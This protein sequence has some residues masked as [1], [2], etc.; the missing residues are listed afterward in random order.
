M[1]KNHYRIF[2]SLL[3]RAHRWG[4]VLLLL[5]MFLG[6]AALPTVA[7]IAANPIVQGVS[8]AQGL[9]Q[10]GRTL[11]ET[12]RFSEA[13]II[14]QRA[15]TAFQS[16]GNKLWQAATLS[17][18]SLVYQQLGEWSEAE[19]A[20]ASSLSLLETKPDPTPGKERFSSGDAT[21]THILAQTLDVRGR[22]Q[23]ARGQADSALNSWKRAAEVYAH[24]GDTSAAIRSRINQATA[25]QALGLY[26]QAQ[27]TLAEANEILQ[28]Q[29]DSALKAA[30]MHKLGNVLRISGD[31]DRA[32]AVLQQSLAVA[33]N[34]RSPQSI[35]EAL[36]SLG[37][38]AQVRGDSQSALNY[39]QQAIASSPSPA[40]KIQI[41]LNQLGLLLEDK[42][43]NAA[44]VL[45]PSILSQIDSLPSS[46]TSVYAR[47]D[48]AR[49]LMKMSAGGTPTPQD[50]QAGETPTPQDSQAGG[51][52]TPQDSQAGETPTPQEFLGR[53]SRDGQLSSEIAQMLAQAVRDAQNLK[54]R[55]AE[56]YALGTLGELYEHTQQESDALNLT[57]QALLIAQTIDGGD[58][59]YQ[60]QW[61]MG[62]LHKTQG[63]MEKAI[64]FYEQAIATL[65]SLR[66][67]LVAIDSNVQ[68]S[69]RE[70]VEPVYRQFV[71]LLLGSPD[72][73]PTQ[74]NLLKARQ[75]I[76]SLQLAEL[77]NFFREACLVA[78]RPIDVVVDQ[79]QTAAFIYPVILPERIEVIF[80]LPQQPLRRYNTSIAQAEV[81]TILAQL[82]QKLTEPDTVKEAQSLSQK[83]YN[84][85]IQPAASDL[86][87][88]QIKT[89]V[90]VLDGALRNIPMAALYDG[91]KY[92]VE[93]YAFALTPGLQLVEPKP[94]EQIQLQ[95]LI[96]G[97]SESRQGFPRL[98]YVENE[99]HQIGTEIPGQT[100]LN[101]QFT[102]QVF[103]NQI[104]L[105]P[106]PVVHLATHGQ[107]SSNA[108]RTFILAWDK[109]IKVNEL[110]SLLRRRDRRQPAAI[111][112]LV[113]SA[114]ET[115][116]GDGR[117]ALGLAGVAIRAG[118]RSTI[119]SLW[120]VEDES[121][122]LLMSQFYQGI[123]NNQLTKAESLRQAQL[124]L[125]QNPQ[126]KRPMSWA[127]YVLVGNWL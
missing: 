106:F 9:M 40:L 127:P 112:L 11:Y 107:F 85:L 87:Q 70:S 65:Q 1:Y 24:M 31:L 101:Q 22:L 63:E 66:S 7:H 96:A 84:W 36:L 95:G 93:K 77:D 86:A 102:T 5:T 29:P 108:D 44:A 98:K 73:Q 99:L 6:A 78:K 79:D 68:F 116:T 71:D 14:L 82:R 76:E 123:T 16:A 23:L 19:K 69:F 47:I 115:A 12:Q 118:A 105:Q 74:E 117:A 2:P 111:E 75:A 122:A 21:R 53:S 3:K 60:W 37:K 121:T 110:N 4:S 52:P 58:I 103:N 15:L 46:R 91:E 38:I 88:S 72:A 32:E 34:V 119:A 45:W 62:R 100:F 39:Y 13:A 18:L 51:T 81:E 27:K 30:G 120:Q 64:A 97:I 57:Q 59:A 124:A 104:N 50:S 83:V 125:L 10:Q 25:M 17:N 113:L 56:S 41:Q 43:S 20:I 94:V 90:F 80:K 35:S 48:L 8:D 92:L 114:C 49:S 109:P 42:Q 26:R 89:L 126:Y 67:D 55:R 61:Q 54:D 28:K 33:R